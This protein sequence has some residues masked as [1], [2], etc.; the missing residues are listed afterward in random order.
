MA[1]LRLVR[2]ATT[3]IPQ[4]AMD[5]HRSVRSSFLPECIR[6][7][8]AEYRGIYGGDPYFEGVL[9]RAAGLG[10][11]T[12]LTFPVRCQA[13]PGLYVY[14]AFL[15]KQSDNPY[16]YLVL[17]SRPDVPP[18]FSTVA[19][20][21]LF[22]EGK[23]QDAEA[24]FADSSARSTVTPFGSQTF[25]VFNGDGTPFSFTGGPR[26]VPP[27]CAER[28]QD[29]RQCWRAKL[30]D[31]S[32]A[33]LCMTTFM[34]CALA[35]AS[36]PLN[37]LWVIPVCFLANEYAPLVGGSCRAWFNNTTDPYARCP[38]PEGQTC[39]TADCMAGTCQIGPGFGIPLFYQWDCVTASPPVPAC[40][41]VCQDCTGNGCV[42]KTVPCGKCKACT[43]GTCQLQ[44]PPS[45]MLAWA[46]VTKSTVGPQQCSC[47]AGKCV[48][49]SSGDAEV[50]YYG[51][52]TAPLPPTVAGTCTAS[53][54]SQQ[55]DL[56]S[57][58]DCKCDPYKDNERAW[59]R[60]TTATAAQTTSTRALAE[61]L[62]LRG[63]SRWRQ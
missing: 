12:T 43:G 6:S 42:N 28:Q 25:Q 7:S 55:E 1:S 21:S 33:T 61:R 27:L 37:P 60:L 35:T 22:P 15:L 18:H 3:R 32:N 23:P 4:P 46:K 5:A 39:R 49:K 20:R 45:G 13:D 2:S 57:C 26:G 36:G 58:G 9:V 24:V 31:L 54:L 40:T 29:Q 41:P 34:T 11:Q 10:Y 44:V 30:G 8:E 19:Y 59:G 48:C 53:G 47:S 17:R 56:L 16:D 50:K 38:S 52:R 63:R 62:P 14:V 51:C